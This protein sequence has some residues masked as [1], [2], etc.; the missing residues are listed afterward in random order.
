MPFGL[1]N[2]PATFQRLMESCL[3]ELHLDWCI[4]YLD[5]III[6]SKDPDEHIT[7]LEGVFEKL[8]KVGLKLKP[9][10]CEFFCSSLKYLGHIVSRDGIAT[11]PKKIEAIRNWPHP[12]TVTD[13]RSFTGFTNYYRKFIKGYAKIAQPLHELTSGDNA[14]HKNQ[15]V[16]WNIRCNDSF[17]ALKSICSECPVLAYADYTKPFVLHTDASTTGLGAV[18]YQKQEDGKERVIVYASRTLNKSERNYN[19]HKLKFLALKWAIT[20]RF[21][22]YLYGATFDVY[23]DNNPLTYILSTAKLDAMGHSWVAS[24]GPY[25]FSLHYKPGK[26]NC[27]VDVLSHINWESISPEVVQATMDLAHVDRTLILDPE[28]RGRK[29]TN[30]PFVLKSLR[31]NKAIRKWQCRQNEDPE[32]RWIIELM[33]NNLWLT[34]KY[35]KNKPSS[36][37]SYVKIRADLK[38]ENGLLYRRIRLKDHEMDTYQLV[39]PVAYRKVTLELLHDK[40]GHL[41]IDRTTGLSCERFFWPR[42]AEEI[43]QYIQNCEHCLRYKQQPEWAELKPLEASYPLELVYMDYLKI[44]GKDDPN[45]NVLVIT[46]HFT[47]YSQAYVTVNQQAAMAAKVF[48]RKFVNNYGWPTKILTDQG[49]T[50]NGKLFTALCKEAKILKLRTSPYHPQTK[51]QPERFNRMLMTMLGTLP[52]DKK[53]NWQDWVSTLCHAYNCTVTKVKGYSPYFLMSLFSAQNS[54]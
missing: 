8:A 7:R 36:I 54:S 45:L 43:R 39:V 28:I 33:R 26:L 10:K 40:F 4:I 42:M 31:M 23:T 24:L 18:L 52:E 35:N 20:D 44:G 50:F 14:K 47:R 21:H 1:T 38:L 12:K 48:V 30:E 51:R 3:A 37:K 17:E 6:F 9:S 53:I 25:N 15:K 46:D 16:D 41:G 34:Y 49:Q 11:D 27:D 22:E 32:I 13:V 29:S 2:M 5:D 19:A